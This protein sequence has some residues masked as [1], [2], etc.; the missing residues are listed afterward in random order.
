MALNFETAARDGLLLEE[1]ERK[2]SQAGLVLR[3]IVLADPT[4]FSQKVRTNDQS[5]TSTGVARTGEGGC[6]PALDGPGPGIEVDE[7]VLAKYPYRLCDERVGVPPLYG[8]W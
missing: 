2:A 3:A 7:S 6:L 4:A 1:V 8:T 5:A